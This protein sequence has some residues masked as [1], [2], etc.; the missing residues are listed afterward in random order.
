ME[1]IVVGSMSI[2]SGF[3]DTFLEYVDEIDRLG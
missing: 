3:F 1:V 2:I